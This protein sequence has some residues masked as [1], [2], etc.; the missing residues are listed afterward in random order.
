MNNSRKV[1][2][3]RDFP[4]EIGCTLLISGSSKEVFNIA[5]RHAVEEHGHKDTAE[6]RKLI[7]IMMKDEAKSKSKLKKVTKKI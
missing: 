5:L 1:I 7:K 3:C 6:I 2:D 4:N